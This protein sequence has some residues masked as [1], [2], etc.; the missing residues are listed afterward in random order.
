MEHFATECGK[1]KNVKKDKSYAELKLSMRNFSVSNG[2]A[3]IAEDDSDE[4]E[5]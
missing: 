5:P 1:P 4:E 2:K 3:Y